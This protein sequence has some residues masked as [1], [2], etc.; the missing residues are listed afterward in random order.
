VTRINRLIAGGD[1]VGESALWCPRSGRLF[2][3]DIV[4]RRIH[5]LTP[6]T[7]QHQTWATPEIA[8]SIGLREDGG[9]VVGLRRHVAYWDYDDHFDLLA[10]IEPD[11]PGNRL[12]EGKVGPDGAFW[13]GTMQ[14]NIGGDGQPIAMNQSSGA[15]YR[16]WQ[17]G[18]VEALTA[19]EYGIC[20]T[21]A[22]TDDDRFLCADTLANKRNR[23]TGKCGH[24][25]H[26]FDLSRLPATRPRRSFAKSAWKLAVRTCSS[27]SIRKT[28]E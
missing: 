5:A 21:M 10:V 28:A 18:R 24:V 27:R 1:V 4:G 13:V 9:A 12:N 3:V 6:A 2:W 11:L 19:R 15:Y 16:I 8:T 23:P 7:G 14:N 22:W 17:S 25:E 20:N 26:R